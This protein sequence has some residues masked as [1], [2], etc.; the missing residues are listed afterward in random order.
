MVSQNSSQNIGGGKTWPGW[1]GA[2]GLAI[3][4]ALLIGALQGVRLRSLTQNADQVS[5]EALDQAVE[6]EKQQLA[7]LKQ[8]PDL[9]FRNLY[10]DWVFLKFL[11]YFGDDQARE[12]TS[13]ALSPDYF[14]IIL[15]RDPYFREGY[16]FLSGSTSMYAGQPERTIAIMNQHLP[17]LSPQI[18][19]RA[20]YIW[21]Y[22]AVDELLFLGDTAAAKA[23]FRQAAAWASTYEDPESQAV[24]ATSLKTAQFLD[25][26]PNSTAAQISA[27][28]MVLSS[29]LDKGTQAV[30]IQRI[31]ALGGRI[32]PDENGNFR[33][34]TPTEP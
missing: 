29:A 19:D 28:S 3:A 16:F 5:Q 13:Y 34:V 22:K 17:Q 32:E 15:D 23:S 12:R 1:L 7:L 9:G 8:L 26:N 6:Q 21:R 11:Q 30:A 14:D 31:E 33:I 27:W 18:P 4:A 2:W 24:A 20:Y 25:Q 10:G